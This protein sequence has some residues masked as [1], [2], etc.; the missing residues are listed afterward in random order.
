MGHPFCKGEK[1]AQQVQQAFELEIAAD[2]R[3]L[4]QLRDIA[5]YIIFYAGI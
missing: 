4:L 2:G 1:Q 3:I 5:S